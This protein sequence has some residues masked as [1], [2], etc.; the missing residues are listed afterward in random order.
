VYN[1]AAFTDVDACED[2]PERAT[3]VNGE[4]AGNVAAARGSSWFSR[5]RASLFW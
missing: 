3:A 1:C 4:G 5:N 2:E